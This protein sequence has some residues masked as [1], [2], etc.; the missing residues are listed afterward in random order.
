MSP[1]PRRRFRP[2]RSHP[3]RP[4]VLPTAEINAAKYT[5]ERGAIALA[6]EV[7]GGDV[8]VRVTDTGIGLSAEQM[9][10]IFEMF[11]QLAS[12]LD[13]SQGGLGIGLS[14]A[15]RLI[16]MHGGEITARSDG[17][18]RGSEFSVRLPRA[19]ALGEQAMAPTRLGSQSGPGAWRVLRRRSPGQRRH[20]GAAVRHAR[21]AVRVAYDGRQALAI[22]ASFHP[23][24]SCST[25]HARS[26]GYKACG[27]FARPRGAAA[28][29][30][31][32]RPDGPA[33]TQRTQEAGFDHHVVKPIVLDA[34]LALLRA[35]RA[36]A[37]IVRRHLPEQHMTSE[38]KPP[39][40]PPRHRDRV[41]T[42]RDRAL[43]QGARRHA[44]R[45]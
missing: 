10:L 30:S 42:R 2:R 45:S 16:E 23:T 27:A 26:H 38:R 44:R 37:R 15:R 6:T 8:V 25:R 22:G 13:R 36:A 9:P 31:S 11:G 20:A 5:R 34:L 1:C 39:T 28:P 19:P 12:A 33:R 4:G 29:R 17:P 43:D 41:H 35:A 24:S 18:G 14:L 40:T 21:H 7:H 32:P 3:P